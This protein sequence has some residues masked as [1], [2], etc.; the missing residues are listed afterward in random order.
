MEIPTSLWVLAH[1]E[2]AKLE[3]Q[4]QNI[5]GAIQLLLKLRQVLPPLDIDQLSPHFSVPFSLESYHQRPLQ[6]RAEHLFQE[7]LYVICEEEKDQKDKGEKDS[8]A[9][10][11]EDLSE[12]RE[13]HQSVLLFESQ[14]ED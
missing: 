3:N 2:I 11:E 5:D 6:Q 1:I 7:G 13:V 9:D 10:A 14:F 4:N 12:E 8:L